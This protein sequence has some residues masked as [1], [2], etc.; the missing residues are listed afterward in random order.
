[1]AVLVLWRLKLSKQLNWMSTQ[2][3]QDHLNDC[4]SFEDFKEMRAFPANSIK[5]G[6]LPVCT[7]GRV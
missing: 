4:M 3:G 2:Y 7:T 1:M 5:A 6:R